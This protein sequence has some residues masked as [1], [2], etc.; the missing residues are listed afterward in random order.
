LKTRWLKYVLCAA[1]AAG[2][3]P[4]SPALAA[5]GPSIS[6][7]LAYQGADRQERLL[8]GAK[9]EGTLTVYTSI[10]NAVAQKLRADFESK[11]GIKVNLW[12]AGDRSVLQ[13]MVSENKA[14]RA[15]VDVVNIGSLE[16]EM[17]H[18]EKILQPVK[19]PLHDALI[20]GAVAPHHEW[21]STFVNIV[22]QAYNTGKVDKQDLPKTYKD[23]LDPRWKGK[24]G[25][26]ATDEEW[27]SSIVRSM[28]EEAGLKY[29]RDLVATNGVSVRNGHSLL[30]NLVAAGEVPFGMTVYSH[31]VLSAQKKGAP[32]NYVL[33]DPAVAVSFSMGISTQPTH[34]HA[35]LLFYEYMLTDGQK[36]FAD[37]NYVPT[38]KDIETPFSNVKYLMVDKAQF[39]D[40]FDKWSGLWEDIIVK[41]Q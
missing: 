15:N 30:A 19:S 11:Y 25:I 10:A 4:A 6:S 28:G 38:R 18:R 26:E 1:L 2:I 31:S 22:V 9:K 17:L 33:L 13:R 32:I 12:R 16:M 14:G 41:R 8:E 23:L 39:L 7:L 24:L 5:D 40:E 35:A 37:M 20:E 36:V 29:F 21:V 34:P 27:F 3:S